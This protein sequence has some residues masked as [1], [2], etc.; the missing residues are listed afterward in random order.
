[1][2]SATR[3]NPTVSNARPNVGHYSATKHA[4]KALADSL[5]A[6]VNPD[7]IRVLSIYPG[8]TATPRMETLFAQEG[9]AYRPEL[10]L[11]PEDIASIVLST[12]MLPWTAEV[13]D[14]RIRPMAKSY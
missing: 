2:P 11:Q 3:P 7:G 5:R 12:V 6:E 14:I 9:R 13:T 1:M 8:R 4:F 10:L